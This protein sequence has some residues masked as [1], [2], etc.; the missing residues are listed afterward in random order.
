MTDRYLQKYWRISVL[1]IN[2]YK[3][4]ICGRRRDPSDLECHHI[5]KRRRLFLRH[6]WKNGVPVCVECHGKAHTLYGSGIIASRH[7]WMDYLMDNE[8]VNIKDYLVAHGMTRDEFLQME[9]DELKK[10]I[11][12]NS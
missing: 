1:V 10:I 5:I 11:A 3:C 6:D 2:N 8:N 9:L 7:E 12:D 4:I